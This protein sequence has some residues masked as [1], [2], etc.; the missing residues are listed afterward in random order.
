MTKS[1]WPR[2]EPWGTPHRGKYVGRRNYYCIWH[3]NSDV[4]LLRLEFCLTSTCHWWRH[5]SAAITTTT[6][7]HLSE[8]DLTPLRHGANNWLSASSCAVRC[9]R[10]RVFI[11]C[12]R[13]SATSPSQTDSAAPKHFNIRTLELLNFEILLYHIVYIYMIRFSSTGTSYVTDF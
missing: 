12:Y 6:R 7:C 4:I 1:G 5:E 9:Q 10:R 13:I 2:T 11:I 3:E 8:P